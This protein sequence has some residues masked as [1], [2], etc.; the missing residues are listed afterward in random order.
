MA[1]FD[2]LFEQIYFESQYN[3][4]I[5]GDKNWLNYPSC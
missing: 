4:S 3:Q 1:N 5:D 2:K